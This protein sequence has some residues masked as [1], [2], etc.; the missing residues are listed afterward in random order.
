MKKS[1]TEIYRFENLNSENENFCDLST[2]IDGV[3]GV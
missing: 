2:P 1:I 3:I